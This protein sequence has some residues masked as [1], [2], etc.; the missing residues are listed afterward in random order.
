MVTCE[1][2]APIF[3]SVNILLVFILMSTNTALLNNVAIVLVGPKFPE[4]IGATARV[5]YNMGISNLIVVT[6]RPPDYSPMAK[7]ATHKATHLLDEMKVYDNL[8]EA[9]ADYSI[10][11]GTSAR[12]GKQ[13]SSERSPRNIIERILPDLATNKAA[14]LFGPENRGLTNDE[15]KYCQHTS[16]IPTAD[17]SS[18][19]L[20]QAVAIHCHELYY[21]VVNA[22]ERPVHQPKVATS[23]ELEGMYQHMEEALTEIDFLQETNNSYWMTSIRN[24]FSR[25]QLTS[26][27]SQIIRGICKQFINH[28]NN[29]K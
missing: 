28:Q 27:D 26:K 15:L 13:R 24:F 21:S 20:A 5:A 25:V 10:V 29:N 8:A 14:I 16:A 3:L 12:S 7:M 9:I 11:I 4:N 2:H 17:F 23:F 19:N 18:L 22:T 6:N 1:Q